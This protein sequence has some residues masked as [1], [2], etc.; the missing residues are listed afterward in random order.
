MKL[1]KVWHGVILTL[2]PQL[3]VG[4]AAMLAQ[5]V[6][7]PALYDLLVVPLVA[8]SVVQLLWV[9]PAAVYCGATAK[10][11]ALAGILGAA[12]GVLLL[13]AACF[14]LVVVSLGE[15]MH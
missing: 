7:V 8:P 13:N 14:G 5:F 15:G 3:C 11:R 9:V 1:E 4:G 2:A 12:A 10:K 6:G